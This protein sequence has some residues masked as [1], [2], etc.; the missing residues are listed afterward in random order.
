MK[1]RLCLAL[2]CRSQNSSR[3]DSY[4]FLGGIAVLVFIRARD[5][6]G[7]MTRVYFVMSMEPEQTSEVID[8]VDVITTTLVN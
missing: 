1:P 3:E 6:I 5:R 8:K 7:T 4:P 2:P